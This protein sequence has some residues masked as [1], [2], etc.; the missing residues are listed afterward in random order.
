[1]SF[2]ALKKMAGPA[3]KTRRGIRKSDAPNAFLKSCLLKAPSIIAM[4]AMNLEK[5]MG[6]L[7]AVLASTFVAAVLAS[8]FYLVFSPRA[9]CTQGAK[10]MRDDATEAG[11]PGAEAM[12]DAFTAFQARTAV[13]RFA[14]GGCQVLGFGLLL[15]HMGDHNLAF[16]F[17]RELSGF[18]AT[19]EK[20]MQNFHRAC[21]IWRAML[22][23]GFWYTAATGAGKAQAARHPRMPWVSQAT[24]LYNTSANV[25]QRRRATGVVSDRHFN[26]NRDLD[27]EPR[28]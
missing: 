15:P 18:Q 9:V 5:Q 11:D 7:Y 22:A 4:S 10:E 20:M 3:E 25:V 28:S 6:L 26:H 16:T 8:G 14:W 23:R 19:C 2:E 17:G 27:E 21:K 12:Q 24:V 13:W 1:M